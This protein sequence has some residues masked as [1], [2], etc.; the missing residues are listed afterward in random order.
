MFLYVWHQHT[1]VVVVAH[2][3]LSFLCFFDVP[4]LIVVAPA[5]VPGTQC[6][7]NFLL[8]PLEILSSLPLP[9]KFIIFASE[10]VSLSLSIPFLIRFILKSGIFIP[11]QNLLLFRHPIIVVHLPT[12]L[13]LCYLLLGHVIDLVFLRLVGI[14][15]LD[16]LFCPCIQILLH[17]MAFLLFFLLL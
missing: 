16:V 2:A 5:Y 15:V 7:L 13:I 1:I 6:I 9:N 12:I 17:I 11:L 14:C 3:V 8:F 4:F 10:H